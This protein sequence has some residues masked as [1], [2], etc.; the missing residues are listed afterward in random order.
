ME[1][2][3]IDPGH[4]SPRTILRIIGPIVLIIGVIFALAGFISVFSSV[5]D[6]QM[7]PPKNFWCLFVGFPLIFIGLVMCQFGFMGKVARYVAGETA[8]VGKDV[9][10]YAADGTKEGIKTIASAV[11]EGLGIKGGINQAKIK[12][13]KCGN[14]N[15]E[16]A[17]FCSSCGVSLA[18]TKPC[19]KCNELNDPDAKFCDNCGFNF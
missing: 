8:P 6:F 15:D 16:A 10:N 11:G 7:G 13:H 2:E 5:N 9:F 4:S 17:K 18:K 12:C 1:E 19:P 3:K 14:L